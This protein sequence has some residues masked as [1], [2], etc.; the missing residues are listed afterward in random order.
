MAK[1][2]SVVYIHKKNWEMY[3]NGGMMASV[4]TL[5]GKKFFPSQT[6]KDGL[7]KGELLKVRLQVAS[8]KH[9]WS[10]KPTHLTSVK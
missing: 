4:L 3:V 6:L 8:K 10:A 9:S 5:V 2:T 7:K 1:K